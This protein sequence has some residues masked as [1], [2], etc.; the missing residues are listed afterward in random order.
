MHS[1]SNGLL[2]VSGER[3]LL[4]VHGRTD[5]FINEY[6]YN[7]ATG[8]LL[9]HLDE[10]THYWYVPSW[11]LWLDNEHVKSNQNSPLFSF[12]GKLV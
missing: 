7:F 2:V 9:S 4:C 6:Y 11:S 10:D 1:N 3:V 5:G 8:E 12:E